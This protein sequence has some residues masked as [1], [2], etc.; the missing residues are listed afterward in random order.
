VTAD[1]W[2]PAAVA[3]L[4]TIS[5]GAIAEHLGIGVQSVAAERQRRDIAPVRP[6]PRPAGGSRKVSRSIKFRQ[7]EALAMD[8]AAGDEPWAS[9]A[10]RR[11]VV[12]ARRAAKAVR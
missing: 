3:L 11:L 8:I 1:P 2:T 6:G 9:W 10:H 5:D 4:G 12:A 7:D